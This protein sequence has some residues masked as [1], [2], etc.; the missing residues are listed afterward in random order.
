MPSQLRIYKIKPGMMDQWLNFF[1]GKVVPMHQQFGIPARIA[2]VNSANSEF[3][4]VRD[5]AAGEPIEDQ[6]RRYVNSE[7]RRRVIGDKSKSYIDGMVVRTVELAYDQ[8]K[9]EHDRRL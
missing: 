9:Q 1:H 3:I 4:W 8:S 7:E 2:W 6:E 5:F